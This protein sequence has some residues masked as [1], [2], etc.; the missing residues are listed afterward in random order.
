MPLWRKYLSLP[1]MV[2]FILHWKLGGVSEAIVSIVKCLSELHV[3]GLSASLIF[4]K[5]TSGDVR[6]MQQIGSK[7]G[8]ESLDVPEPCVAVHSLPIVL[9]QQM[10]AYF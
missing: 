8:V 7:A 10:V 2:I 6:G 3:G 9:T 1:A 4:S 5:N